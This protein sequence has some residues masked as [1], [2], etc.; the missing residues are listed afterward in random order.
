MQPRQ[1]V[2]AS[3]P[4]DGIGDLTAIPSISFFSHTFTSRTDPWRRKGHHGVNGLN[5]NG[6][7]SSNRTSIRKVTKDS[8]E[9]KRRGKDKRTEE[10]EVWKVKDKGNEYKYDIRGLRF[11]LRRKGI[12]QSGKEWSKKRVLAFRWAKPY[13]YF[14]GAELLELEALQRGI[15]SGQSKL[16]KDDYIYLNY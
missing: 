3:S 12:R 16:P 14:V 4:G 7:V 8:W 1:I 13:S 6:W 11:F 2:L 10:D 5:G 9:L 15:K